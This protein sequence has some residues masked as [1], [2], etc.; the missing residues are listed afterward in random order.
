MSDAEDKTLLSKTE[1]PLFESEPL[2]L[3]KT[4]KQC[5]E[6]Q[7]TELDFRTTSD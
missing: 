5:F 2:Y 7:Q 4:A 6:S 3:S 1:N